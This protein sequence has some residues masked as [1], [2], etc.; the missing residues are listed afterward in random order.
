MVK[1]LLLSALLVIAASSAR[2]Q[3]AG[4]GGVVFQS[5]GSNLHVTCDSGCSSSSAPA[6]ESAFTAGTTSQ[7]PIGGMYQTT[8]TSNPLTNGQMGAVQLTINRG[9]MVNLRSA[10][11]VEE[12][13]AAN[14]LGVTPT[15]GGA[16]LSTT[17]G[18]YTNLL[19][20]NA[21]LASGNPLFAQLTT[22]SA[23]I[24]ALTAN[25]SVNLSQVN[26][27]TTLAGA[28][29]S[30]TGAQRVTASQDTTTIAGSA[31]GTAG[32]A[33]SNV[34]TVQGIA[35]MTPVQVSQATAAN[36]NATV[37]GTVTTTPRAGTYTIAGCTVGITSAS[38][39]AGSTVTN[40]VMIQNNSA[41]A[42][43]ACAW[44][45]GTAVLA[46]NGSVQLF[47]GQSMTWGPNTAG[48]PSGAMDCIASAASTPL[49]VEYN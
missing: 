4:G 30:G 20:G 40:H 31:P 28:G 23:T 38:C 14:G 15:Q 24:G 44:A 12:G 22:G 13:T 45:T 42:T 33:S 26:G 35:S 36:L 10:V 27:V 3:L 29:A 32:S 18:G 9:L 7:T 43:V 49:Y 16:V 5:V 25:Q 47:P 6:D 21:V 34:L 8:A 1:K 2:A 11:G 48:I 39:I 19:Q 46:S 41:T 37:T 17:N